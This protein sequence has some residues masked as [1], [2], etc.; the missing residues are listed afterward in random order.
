MLICSAEGFAPRQNATDRRSS[1]P[2]PRSAWSF[3]V[4]R[5]GNGRRLVPGGVQSAFG[6]SYA[7]DFDVIAPA[8]QRWRL[9]VEESR[10]GLLRRAIQ[11]P[12]NG[13]AT[14]SGVDYLGTPTSLGATLA[15]P[16][17]SELEIDQRTI[18]GIEGTGTLDFA[19]GRTASCVGLA[20]SARISHHLYGGTAHPHASV[21]QASSL[22]GCT[23]ARSP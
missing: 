4:E 15:L 1:L 2:C 7:I 11:A 8:G 5:A 3:P 20:E 18:G 9:V 17:P 16:E 6:E 14:N 19:I 22:G 13:V 23:C 21:G 12:G 10:S